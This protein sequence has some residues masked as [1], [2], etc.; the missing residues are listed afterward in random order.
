MDISIREA[1]ESDSCSILSLVYN[2]LG[3]PEVTLDELTSRI[4]GMKK[5]GNYYIVVALADNNVV[6]L[7]A[8]VQEMALEIQN[9]YF[10]IIDLIISKAYQNKGIGRSLL[11][12]ME[13][14][15]SDMGISYL[16][17]SSGFQRLDAHAFYEHNGYIKK[18]FSFSK[19]TK[20]N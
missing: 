18:S 7:I 11:R 14:L 5:A 16:T 12:Y 17:L 3:Y 9:D 20:H 6:G 4:S 19:G 10:R 8:A 15:A 13:K 2:E 1:C